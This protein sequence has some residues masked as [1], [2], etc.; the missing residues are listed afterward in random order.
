[1][2]YVIDETMNIKI[3]SFSGSKF[4]LSPLKD[5]GVCSV[6]INFFWFQKVYKHC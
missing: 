5:N 4:D 1:M 3:Y 6:S 2:L